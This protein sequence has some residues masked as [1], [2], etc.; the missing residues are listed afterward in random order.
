MHEPDRG[1]F[2]SI[3]R[4]LLQLSTLL[5]RL[6]CHQPFVQCCL[7]AVKEPKDTFALDL[8]KFAHASGLEQE[9]PRD[10]PSWRVEVVCASN[11]SKSRIGRPVVF[12]Q[13]RNQMDGERLSTAGNAVDREDHPCFL[14]WGRA[15]MRG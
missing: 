9:Q 7:P 3:D 10:S 2:N 6:M 4:V 5:A 12:G 11:L 1:F 8:L 13:Q 14:Q 15:T